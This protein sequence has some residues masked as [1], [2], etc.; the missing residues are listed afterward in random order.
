M[1]FLMGRVFGA[2][3]LVMLLSGMMAASS[4]LAQQRPNRAS[5]P[6]VNVSQEAGIAATHRGEWDQFN[7]DFKQGYVAIGQAWGDYDNDGWADLYVTGNLDD[8]V[9]YRNNAD[10]TFSISEFSDRVSL[11]GVLS[12][13]TVWADYDNDGWADLYVANHGPNT[14]FRNLQGR[15]F[16]DVTAQAGVGDPRKSKTATWGDYNND[17]WLDLY[18][19]NWS[20]YPECGDL[21]AHDPARDTLYRNNG[22]GTFTDVSHLLVYNRLLGAGFAASFVDYDLDGDVDVYVVND[23]LRNP[24]GNVLWRNDGPGCE[25]WCW[26]D[27]SAESSAGVQMYAM[28]LAIG[29]YN[30]DLTPDFFVT[31]F[32]DRMP[33][34][35]N[36]GDGTFKNVT[37][38]ARTEIGPGSA[39]GWG[40][41]FFDYDND[42]WL[43]LYVTASRFVQ[44]PYRGPQGL[45]R[46]PETLLGPHRDYLFRNNGDGT[47]DDATPRQWQG[48][49]HAT[50]G[51]ACADYDNDGWIDYVLGRWDEGYALFHNNTMSDHH[52]LRIRLVGAGPVNRDAVGARVYL[53]DDVGRTQMQQVVAGSG[54][55]AGNDLTLHFGL[56]NAQ[57]S[58]L[59]V[60]WPNNTESFVQPGAVNQMLRLTYPSE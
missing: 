12:G 6:F 15:G 60:V 28:G 59:R 36:Q 14:L 58:H 34:L 5:V 55:G 37:R 19:A 21:Q 48:E 20:C 35:Q 10:G 52:W 16:L 17:G 1:L 3:W 4:V 2:C 49:P 50:M 38:Q 30:N 44:T 43:D 7:P 23:R 29:D 24:I 11:P 45:L 54:L 51:I 33:L 18:I 22:D 42:G 25:G 40:T 53:T 47:F 8:N 13:G 26:T 9:L 32:T 27:V 57:A 56:G 39:V 41:A 46:P 31:N